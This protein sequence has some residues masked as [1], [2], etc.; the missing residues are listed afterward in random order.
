MLMVH[1]VLSL[2]G[3]QLSN[4]E[5]NYSTFFQKH[6]GHLRLGYESGANVVGHL[7][8]LRL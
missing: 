7:T 5:L 6:Y 4:L 2:P 3:F 1:L 8:V